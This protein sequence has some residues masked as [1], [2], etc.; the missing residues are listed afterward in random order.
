MTTKTIFF[1]I[2]IFASLLFF[3]VSLS[4][5][6]NQGNIPTSQASAVP[7]QN[8][9]QNAQSDPNSKNNLYINNG[10]LGLGLSWAPANNAMYSGFIDIRYWAN[11][12]FGIEGGIGMIRSSYGGTNN[13]LG[14]TPKTFQLTTFQL[15]GMVP[16]IERQHFIF[17]GDLDIVP[18]VGSPSFGYEILLGI[19]VEYA[20]PEYSNLSAYLQLNPI[21]AYGY[22][23]GNYVALTPAFMGFHFY[24]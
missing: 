21:P 20:F 15:E 9:Q 23:N 7:Q 14:M 18:E 8:E 19:G 1:L 12:W 5:G 11:R 6:E 4:F 16:I 22:T 13:L 3:N 17:Y 24:F 2:P 10:K